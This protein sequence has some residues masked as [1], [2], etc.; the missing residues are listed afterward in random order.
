MNND[1]DSISAQDSAIISYKIFK[2]Y[3]RV[4]YQRLYASIKMGIFDESKYIINT[5]IIEQVDTVGEYYRE[6]QCTS[7][8]AYTYLEW[9][10]A[11]LL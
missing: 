9:L 2:M 4:L 7:T 11:Y 10:A 8:I 3:V 5:G 1:M 6:I